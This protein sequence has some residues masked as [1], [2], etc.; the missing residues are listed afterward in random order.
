MQENDII[1][2]D[3][4]HC[5]PDDLICILQS[6]VQRIHGPFYI[7]LIEFF[8]H[9]IRKCAE[10]RPDDLCLPSGYLPDQSIRHC[11][12]LMRLFPAQGREV[13][14]MI[15]MVA[16][17]MPLLIHPPYDP[18]ISVFHDILSDQEKGR[19]DAPLLQPV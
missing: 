7:E 4:C 5:P 13:H 10:G 1:F 17:Q 14:M 3:I 6:P 8:F 9:I 15:G 18:L 2:F 16:D 11:Q 19:L 12:L